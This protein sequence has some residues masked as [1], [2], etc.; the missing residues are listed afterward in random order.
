[1]RADHCDVLNQQLALTLVES[2]SEVRCSK[3]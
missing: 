3:R 1:M 2:A